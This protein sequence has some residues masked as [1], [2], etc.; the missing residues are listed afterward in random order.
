MAKR[1]LLEETGYESSDWQLLF[2]NYDYPT[3]EIN[4]V[5]VYLAKNAHRVADQKLDISEKIT[6]YRVPLAE[7]VQMCMENKIAVN[8][9]MAALLLAA[10]IYGI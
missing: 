9:S 7:T 3:K 10:K 5:S 8:G 4:T 2:T 6:F 1:E